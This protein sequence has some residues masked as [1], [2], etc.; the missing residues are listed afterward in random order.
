MYSDMKKL[1]LLICFIFLCLPVFAD[2]KP[3]PANLGKQYKAEMESI[4]NKNYSTVISDIDNYYNEVKKTGYEPEISIYDLDLFLY[5]DMMKV[6]QEKY[7]G[8][9]YN[10]RGTDCA[11]P[12]ANFLSPYFKDN[13]VNTE[14]LIYI[15][16]YAE[17]KDKMIDEYRV[18][19]LY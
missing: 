8:V 17:Q 15:K 10:P 4:I 5:A 11:T 14:K 12:A 9:K 7:L 3:I 1:F 18:Q 19:K 2:Y 6:T 16:H 13:K